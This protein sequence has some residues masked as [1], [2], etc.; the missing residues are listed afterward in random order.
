MLT[1]VRYNTSHHE[2]QN[3][4]RCPGFRRHPDGAGCSERLADA[5]RRRQHP[6][7]A[8][9]QINATNVSRLQVAWTYD[10]HD[11]F[12]GSEMQSNPIVVDGVLY[13]TTPTL[14]VVAVDA[15]TGAEIWK[16]DPSGGATAAARVPP[17]RRHGP[18][19]SRVR[20]LPQLAV[21]ARQEDRDSRSRSFGDRRAHRSA[22]RARSAG[23]RG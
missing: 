12:K 5:R 6:L 2:T 3:I 13:A 14:K 23:R 22:R 20:H 15:A 16:F 4:D 8:L 19:G 21:G 9:T 18:Q 10:S 7:L 17:S 11:A 1:R